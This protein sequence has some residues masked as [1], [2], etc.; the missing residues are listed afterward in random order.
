MASGAKYSEEYTDRLSDIGKTDVACGWKPIPEGAEEETDWPS[1]IWDQVITLNEQDAEHGS[2][3]KYRSIETDV[4]AHAMERVTGKRLPQIFSDELWS[5]IGAERDALFTVDSSG[6]G[7]ACG[8][9][10]AT[11]RDYM[12]FGLLHLND[13]FL[14]GQQIVSKEW[15]D[16]IRN[17]DHG[18]FDDVGREAF[19]NGCYRNQFWIEDD[20]RETVMCF[21]VFGQLI[22]ISPEY[23]LVAVKLSTWPEFL[24]FEFK[25]N[26]LRAIHAIAAELK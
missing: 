18:M 19:P 10:N 22:Y 13:G 25:V 16:D 20:D 12:R 5:K 24:N 3:F 4:I 7:L 17:G 15:I 9:F 8:G 2:R 23:N 14:N 11:L 26:T 6:Y 1:C 21:G